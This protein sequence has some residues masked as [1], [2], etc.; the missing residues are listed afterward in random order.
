M[1]SRRNLMN[2]RQAFAIF[3]FS[4]TFLLGQTCAAQTSQGR[5]SG[6]VVDASGGTVAIATVTIENLGTHVQR[7]LRTN[8][9]GEY[10]APGIE[11][12]IYSITVEAAGFSKIIRERVQV[13]VANDIKIDFQLKPGAITEVV[14][15][16]DETPLTETT[17]AVL[18]GVLANKAI[19]ELPLQG[20]DFQN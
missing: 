9:A 13:E 16:K 14:E 3:L 10:V 17:N 15:V 4:L 20:R 19:N 11:P 12:G 1:N 8:G 6:Q 5:V 2:S 18:S 7:V